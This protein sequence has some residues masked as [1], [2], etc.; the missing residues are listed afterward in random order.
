M[1]KFLLL[2]M[3]LISCTAVGRSLSG[4]RKRRADMLADIL[5]A[6]RVLRL[7][8]LNSMEPVGVLLRKSELFLFRE[9]GNGL[10]E[11][12]CLAEC[13]E[14]MRAAF[15][16]RGNPLDCLSV[17]DLDIM[18]VFFSNLGR[19]G[20]EE[21]NQLFAACISQLEEAQTAAKN[22][23]SDSVRL[24]TAL[25]ALIGVGICILLI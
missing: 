7:R 12:S 25:G 23:F 11:G 19:S 13:W 14:G 5:A 2:S 20:R 8:M 6:M 24:Y 15:S 22:C 1:W 16:R 18:D 17:N 10:W 21:Q 9:L 4:A 3:I